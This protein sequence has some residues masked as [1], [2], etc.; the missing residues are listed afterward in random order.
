[1]NQSN[2][3]KNI[4]K[5]Y[6]SN[7]L[8]SSVKLALKKSGQEDCSLNLGDISGFDEL[9]VGGYKSSQKLFQKLALTENSKL[10]D[11]GSGLGGPAR[12]L[13]SR[14]HV[15]VTGLDLTSDFCSTSS[16][17]SK[18]VSMNDCTSFINGNVLDMPFKKGSFDAVLNQH[19]CMNIP[20]KKSLYREVYQVLKKKGRF[21]IHEIFSNDTKDVLYPVPWSRN[22]EISHLISSDE[23]L[24]IMKEMSFKKVHYENISE[25]S[26]NW[27]KNLK[28]SDKKPSPLNQF[29]IF[30]K[31]LKQMALNMQSNLKENRIDVIQAIFEK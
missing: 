7:D 14:F 1:M 27:Y 10:L 26:L 9:H 25:Y 15:D 30:G 23:F 2:Y 28:S 6:G 24:K 29:L 19:F 3:E 8:L 12:T 21:I 16:Y 31:D 13:A 18:I 20:D 4:N 5:Q 17:L 22:R 11:C